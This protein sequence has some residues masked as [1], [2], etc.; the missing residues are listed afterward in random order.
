MLQ[1]IIFVFFVF[2]SRRDK[3]NK[4][5]IN[6]GI[7]LYVSIHTNPGKNPITEKINEEEIAEEKYNKTNGMDLISERKKKLSGQKRN[8]LLSF[9][10]FFE[11]IFL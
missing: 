11:L 8:N 9:F 1:E 4:R 7:F 6:W 3:T 5:T 10:S 2:C